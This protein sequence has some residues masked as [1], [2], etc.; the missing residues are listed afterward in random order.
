MVPI[1]A[2]A[3]IHCETITQQY[4]LDWR[5]DL[6]PI[7][8]CERIVKQDAADGFEHSLTIYSVRKSDEGEYGVV[9]KDSYTAVTKITV[10]GEQ[11]YSKM[12]F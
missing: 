8:E 11:L 6:R 1:G 12:A 2:A 7:A 10:V 3:T 5:K 9:I 4:S